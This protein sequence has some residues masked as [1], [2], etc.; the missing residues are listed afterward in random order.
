MLYVDEAHAVGIRGE[1][2]LGCAEEQNCIADIDLLTGTFGKA[3][4]SVG[5][6]VACSGILR[7]WL[8]NR[9]RTLIFTTAL[10][11][12]NLMWTRFILERLPEFG[13]RR[14][15]LHRNSE[16]LRTLIEA[17]GFETPSGSHI[18]PLIVGDSRE[19][20]RKAEDMRRAGF[21]VLP[22]RP[23]TVPEGT[24]RIRI[25]LTADITADEVRR[26]VRSI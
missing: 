17:K 6:Y 20:V 13:A 4:A 24:S 14:E 9:M 7:E 18:V 11:P 8:V 2:G 26:I 23:P 22:V 16:L 1:R 19:A 3:L 10:P 15:R 5:G 12:V 21:Y 25:S